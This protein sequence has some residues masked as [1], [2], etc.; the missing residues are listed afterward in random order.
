[1]SDTYL[2]IIPDDSNFIP[3][4][5]REA[6]TVE[7]LIA[8]LPGAEV[9]AKRSEEVQFIDPGENFERVLCPSCRADLTNSWPSL[10][11][12]AW[13]K[14][15]SD[16]SFE[17]PC[18]HTPANLNRLVYEWPTGFARFVVEVNV[19]RF[20]P[21]VQVESVA[22]SLGCRVRQVLSRY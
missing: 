15:F 13:T 4:T 18:C 1:M 12:D 8:L 14:K 7:L 3:S 9:V 11:D 22:E 6:T 19:G 16:L 10:V 17:T 5:E 20:L 21:E 2:R